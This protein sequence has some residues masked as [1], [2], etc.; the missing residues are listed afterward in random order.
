MGCLS[1]SLAEAALRLSAVLRL[2][3]LS[4]QPPSKGLF[5]R[6]RFERLTAKQSA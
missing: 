6:R 2:K 3:S 5:E 1:L 4:N